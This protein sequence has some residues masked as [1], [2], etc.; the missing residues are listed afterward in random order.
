MS[1]L[2]LKSPCVGVCSTVYGDDVC[3][4]CKRYYD[5]V[6]AWNAWTLPQKQAVY[7]RMTDQMRTVM[8]ERLSCLDEGKLNELLRLHGIDATHFDCHYWRLY[9]LWVKKPEALS[10]WDVVGAQLVHQ[11]SSLSPNDFMNE[12]DDEL[13]RLALISFQER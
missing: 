10:S 4:G 6:I 8:A 9:L 12:V 5:E 2:D 1:S 13:N 7:A 3:K 11:E